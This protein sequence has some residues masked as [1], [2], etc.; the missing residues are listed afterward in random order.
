[1]VASVVGALL[2]WLE[3]THSLSVV[4]LMLIGF[5][6]APIFASLISLTPARVGETHA[7]SAIGFQVAAAGLGGAALTA[8]V[9]VVARVGGLEWIGLCIVVSCVLVLSLYE[10]F[11]RLDDRPTRKDVLRG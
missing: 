10:A 1:M 9:G 3:P 7:N 6:F 11:V 5:F 8:L 4:G 2:F